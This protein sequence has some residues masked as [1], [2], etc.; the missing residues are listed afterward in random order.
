MRARITG[1]LP[2]VPERV[3][4]HRQIARVGPAVLLVPTLGRLTRVHRRPAS[5]ERRRIDRQSG[6]RDERARGERDDLLIDRLGLGRTQDPRRGALHGARH[7][8]RG[9]GVPRDEPGRVQTEPGGREPRLRRV[10][11]VEAAVGVLR[12]RPVAQRR[13]APR[14]GLGAV[15]HGQPQVQR[16]A[17][18]LVEHEGALHQHRAREVAHLVVPV[19]AIEAAV[20]GMLRV[21]TQLRQQPWQGPDQQLAQR[22][23]LEVSHGSHCRTSSRV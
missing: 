9:H 1:G 10:V 6:A 11:L 15:A 20:R 7:L 8:G 17:R 13:I 16:A 22:G 19:M 18:E 12:A 23:A 4:R 5:F 14:G 2:A 3:A 21:T